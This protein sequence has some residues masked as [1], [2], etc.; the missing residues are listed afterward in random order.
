M[1]STVRILTSLF[2][3]HIFLTLFPDLAAQDCSYTGLPWSEKYSK[4]ETYV[5]FSELNFS[6][7]FI[8]T[9]NV[10]IHVWRND[11]G[12][13]IFP[14]VNNAT[15]NSRFAQ[16]IES[17]NI[18]NLMNLVEPSDPIY[19]QSYYSQFTDTKIR[20][21]LTNIYYH[22]NSTIHYMYCNGASGA[23]I[24]AAATETGYLPFHTVYPESYYSAK[25]TFMI[26]ITG[27]NCLPE[28]T[29]G[30]ATSPQYGIDV[31]SPQSQFVISAGV[32]NFDLLNLQILA[33]WTN[34]FLHEFAHCLGIES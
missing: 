6:P 28:N 21:H 8:K 16:I 27:S 20:L 23:Q 32:G 33:V 4:Q 14:N 18:I 3:S 12:V 2:V 15:N 9:I 11:N 7:N 26:H 31:N 29:I 24:S 5:P 1:S 10:S 19:S 13:G 25:E 30:I 17:I 34:T 22:N